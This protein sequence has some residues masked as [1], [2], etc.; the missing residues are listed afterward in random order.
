M[1]YVPGLWQY[2]PIGI[3]QL[4]GFRV[5][6]FKYDVW[7]LPIWGQLGEVRLSHKLILSQNEVSD[8]KSSRFSPGIE[9]LCHDLLVVVVPDLA[10][11]SDLFKQVKLF[12]K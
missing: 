6:L 7:A 9:I 8:L 1:F 4:V 2:L 5:D 12:S 11:M 10:C 3:L